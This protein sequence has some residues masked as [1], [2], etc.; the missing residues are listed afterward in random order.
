MN[1][2]PQGLE[3]VRNVIMTTAAYFRQLLAPLFDCPECHGRKVLDYSLSPPRRLTSIT[4][5]NEVG[6]E[7]REPCRMCKGTGTN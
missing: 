3:H 4:R 7:R 1:F 2:T 6:A 5:G